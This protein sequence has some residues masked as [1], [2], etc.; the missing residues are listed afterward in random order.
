[1]YTTQPLVQNVLK[2]FES[3]ADLFETKYMGQLDDAA[4]LIGNLRCVYL[5]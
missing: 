4:S 5:L 3:M 2:A 1:M